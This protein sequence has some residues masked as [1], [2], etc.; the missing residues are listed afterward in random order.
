MLLL[1]GA[2]EIGSDL[3]VGAALFGPLFCDENL[4]LAKAFRVTVIIAGVVWL[5]LAD[6]PEQAQTRPPVHPDLLPA[7]DDEQGG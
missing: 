1:A 7:C 2:V 3:A 4:T 6:R 5:K